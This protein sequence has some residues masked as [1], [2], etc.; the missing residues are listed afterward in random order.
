MAKDQ[1]GFGTEKKDPEATVFSRL[2]HSFVPQLGIEGSKAA[3]TL[4]LQSDARRPE[5]SAIVKELEKLAPKGVKVRSIDVSKKPF[6]VLKNPIA[7]AH[8]NPSTKTAY[9]AQRGINPNPGLLAHEL[10]HAKQYTNPSSLINKLQAP[11]R[12]A[13]YYHLTSIPLLFA[14]D[15]NTAKAM[16]GVG[17]AASVPLFAHEMDASIKGRKMLMK[18]ASKSGNKLGFLK[19]LA[20]FKGMPSYLLAL[21]SPYLMYKYLKSKGQYKEN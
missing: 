8:Y 11:S 4:A 12:L 19:S 13:N 7:G 1:F 18:A 9:T 16:A 5:Y 15:E 3:L 17:T 21:G 14:K 10:G 6:E 20:P 2:G